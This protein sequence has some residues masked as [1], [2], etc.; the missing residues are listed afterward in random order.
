MVDRDLGGLIFEVS[1]L[2]LETF[3]TGKTSGRH[4]PLS[5]GVRLCTEDAFGTDDV[6]G[7]IGCDGNCMWRRLRD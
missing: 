6:F 1:D 2:G 5:G 7:K 3:E 4:R